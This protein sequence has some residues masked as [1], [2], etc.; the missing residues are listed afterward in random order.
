MNPRSLFVLGAVSVLFGCGSSEEPYKATPAW[1]GRK[2][3]VPA[4]PPL[5][6]QPIKAGDAYTVYGTV[7][8]MRSRIH[9]AEVT[10]KEIAIV[11]Y[12]IESNISTAPPC[13]VHK[14]GKKDPEDCLNIPIPSFTIAD[15]KDAKP[16]DAKT[17]RIRVMGWAANF[18]NVFEAME[19]YK[20]LKEAPKELYKDELWAVDVP[21]PLPAVGA[22]VKVTGKYGV[23][24]SK[25]SNGI[26]ADPLNG[27]MTYG[28]IEVLEPAPEPAA[29][30]KEAGGG[31][32]PGKG[33][34]AVAQK[35]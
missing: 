31:A 29:F 24:F 14:T 30:S 5:P 7:H 2:A 15:T 26:V 17:P 13:A 35:K 20:N 11:G 28:K 9:G 32:A 27:I 19:K 8:H 16:T 33:G 6:S 22:K 21:Y 25:S 12:I 10:G 23:N 4:P 3:N 1:S 34:K 18:A